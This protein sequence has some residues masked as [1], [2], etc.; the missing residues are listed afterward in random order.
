[1]EG[2]FRSGLMLLL[3]IAL[4]AAALALQIILLEATGWTRLLGLAGILLTVWGLVA[5]RTELGGL[6]RQRRGEIALLR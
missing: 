6:V 1:M 2:R 4:L 5:L 3:G